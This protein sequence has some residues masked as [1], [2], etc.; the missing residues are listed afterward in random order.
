MDSI[1]VLCAVIMLLC[2]IASRFSHRFGMP[3]LLLFMALGMVFCS[4]GCCLKFDGCGICVL[5]IE[6]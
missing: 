6:I 4:D 2:I 1:I 5:N 3:A